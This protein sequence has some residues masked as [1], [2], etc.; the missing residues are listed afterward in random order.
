MAFRQNTTFVIGAGASHEFGLP[1]GKGL[2]IEI[3]KAASDVGPLGSGDPE[4]GYLR[5]YIN[6]TSSTNAEFGL[7]QTTARQ[8]HDGIHTAV[9]IDAFIHRHR[10]SDL[11]GRL[12]K[13]LIA[14][15]VL[16]AEGQSSMSNTNWRHFV[17]DPD[18]IILQGKKK[19]SLINPDYTWIGHFFRTLCDGIENPEDIGK[20]VT[21]ICF[22]YDRCIEHYLLENLSDAYLISREEAQRIVETKIKI[23]HPYGSL[24]QIGLSENDVRNG[25]LTFGQKIDATLDIGSL[26][27]DIRTYTEQ[28]HDSEQVREIHEAIALCKNLVFLGFGFN[29]QNLNL[30]RV[31]ST[32]RDIETNKNVYATGFGLYKQIEHTLQRRILDLFLAR[33]LQESWRHHVHIEFGVGCEEL[34]RMHDMNLSAFNQSFI[35]YERGEVLVHPTGIED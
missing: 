4:R 34:F 28:A 6:S 23:I 3:K 32:R 26:S 2:A 5:R 8:I 27:K 1:V 20:N 24:G 31:R 13:V 35:S 15:E 30:L 29:N 21:I 14:M 18:S 22:N 10:Q 16:K 25:R 7:A 11:L 12:G 19:P 17:S 9:S 33:A